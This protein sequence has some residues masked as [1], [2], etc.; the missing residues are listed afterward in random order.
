MAEQSLSV[1]L[2]GV[3]LVPVKAV[4]R[5]PLVGLGHES[6][7]SDLGYNGS[8]GDGSAFG[9]PFDQRKLP[10]GKRHFEFTVNKKKIRADVGF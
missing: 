10:D 2:G 3:P 6:I 8:G 4:H 1:S 5:K 9:L 7:P